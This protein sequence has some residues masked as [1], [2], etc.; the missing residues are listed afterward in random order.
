MKDLKSKQNSLVCLY[1]VRVLKNQHSTHAELIVHG[2]G[3]RPTLMARYGN[4]TM[5]MQI[6]ETTVCDET[7]LVGSNANLL[8]RLTHLDWT[9]AEM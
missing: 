5:V 7:D 4:E 1:S 6:T 3:M 2:M 9:A 8:V